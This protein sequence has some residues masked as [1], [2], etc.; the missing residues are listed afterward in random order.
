MI[1]TME[2][3]CL[4]WIEEL[5]LI[6]VEITVQL[7]PQCCYGKWLKAEELGIGEIFLRDLNV[8]KLKL[9]VS[10]TL[11]PSFRLDVDVIIC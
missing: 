1:E 10:L 6:F 11:Y 3:L 7:I 5:K 4:N 8:C 2:D 9:F